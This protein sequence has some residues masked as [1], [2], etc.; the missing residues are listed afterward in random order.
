MSD[1]ALN[2]NEKQML[3]NQEIKYPAIFLLGAQGEKKKILF[4][5]LISFSF[6]TIY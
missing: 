1:I 5:F 4:V 6:L 3:M 2:I